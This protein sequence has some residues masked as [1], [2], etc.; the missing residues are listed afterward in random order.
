MAAIAKV[1]KEALNSIKTFHRWDEIRT[2]EDDDYA[3][4]N[5][6][7]EFFRPMKKLSDIL[8]GEQFS[9]IQ[10]LRRSGGKLR[11]MRIIPS[12]EHLSRIL[13]LSFQ[14]KNKNRM[15]LGQSNICII[16]YF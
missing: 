5:L 4:I 3:L 1:N 8:S 16:S 13:A 15:Y 7:V 6:F 9:I 10:G 14:G 11:N 12:F 2:L